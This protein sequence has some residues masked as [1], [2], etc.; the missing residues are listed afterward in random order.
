MKLRV[1]PTA[2]LRSYRIDSG[3]IKQALGFVPRHTIRE[4]VAGICRAYRSGEI[5]D[6]LTDP[7]YVN[8]KQ[9]KQL[10]SGGESSS[11][12]Y[13]FLQGIL[14]QMARIRQVELYLAKRYPEQEMRCPM[15]LCLGQESVAAVFGALAKER[16]VFFGN[17]RS[18]G[19][20]LAK[21]GGLVPLFAELL[22]RSSGCSG[23]MGGSMHMFDSSHGFFGTSAI[24]ASTIPIAAGVALGFKYREEPYAAVCFFG[25]AAMEEGVF[26]ETVNFALLHK[27][28][29]IFVCEN[30]RLAVATPLELRTAAPILS[31]RFDGM[32]L[33][34]WSVRGDRVEE[35]VDAA[36]QAYAWAR[37]G[38]GP[39]LVEVSVN[40]WAVHVGP[41]TTGPV[42]AW[43][44]DPKSAD[45]ASCPIGR[46]AAWLQQEGQLIPEKIQEMRSTIQ[47]EIEAAYQV[48]LLAPLPRFEGLEELSY[49]SGREGKLPQVDI[50]LGVLEKSG[51]GSDSSRLVNPF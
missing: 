34:S 18:H 25:D 9:M 44:Q 8:I 30:N 10:N 51:A 31:R 22:G 12:R 40:R 4:A 33:K 7:R 42:D 48:A 11:D 49:A 27:L 41:A 20:Y 21:G 6:A 3:K 46:L 5:P 50:P 19:H 36:A 45:A 38:N 23:G 16:D 28:P 43:W 35:M 37:S 15:H 1:E 29:V 26:Y 47:S 24:V 39:C 32:N 17:Y 14:F 2:D 13:L